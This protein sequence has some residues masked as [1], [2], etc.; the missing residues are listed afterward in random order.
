[1]ILKKKFI[2]FGGIKLFF[3]KINFDVLIIVFNKF[4]FKLRFKI[5]VFMKK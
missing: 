2:K 1:M 3:R 4:M 5:C